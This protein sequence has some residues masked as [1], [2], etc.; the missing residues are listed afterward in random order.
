[1]FLQI[2]DQ[3]K[4]ATSV[5]PTVAANAPVKF[6]L[7]ASGGI[8]NYT[9]AQIGGALPP[10]VL[11]S[12]STATI[13]G[14]TSAIGAFGLILQVSDA[15]PP[16]QTSDPTTLQF[17]VGTSLGRNNS[18]A[19][20]TQL[21]NGTYKA[22]LSPVADPPT[23]VANPDSDYYSI[24][25]NPGSFVTVEI[26]AVRL[27]PP[28]SLDP[29]LEF[30]DSNNSQLS[31]CASIGDSPPIFDRLCVND[32]LTDSTDSRLALLV[33]SNNPGPLTFYAHVL[34]FRGDARPDFVYTI[35]VSGSN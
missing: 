4:V 35:T 8:G 33:P 10:G 31:Y 26:T 2:Y 1:M 13:S 30:V 22:S 21:S 16:S 19:T 3:V 6:D 34:D 14:Q 12:P 7:R 17:T 18:L 29:V 32:D 11:F 27:D 25:A 23:G 28:S 24:T 20:A 5:L 9:W 15:G